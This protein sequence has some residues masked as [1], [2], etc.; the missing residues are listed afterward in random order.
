MST[1]Q[2]ISPDL[3]RRAGSTGDP[4]TRLPAEPEHPVFVLIAD[5]T[6]V[7]P[8]CLAGG[9]LLWRRAALG[10]MAGAGLLLFY[11]MLLI[12]LLPVLV[13][14]AF[15]DGSPVD[16]AG[17]VLMLGCGLICL[18]LFARFVRGAMLEET[19]TISSV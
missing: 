4:A 9:Y 15:Y 6:T 5:F 12:G 19:K 18:T 8:A 16:V 13:F 14:P 17:I 10:Y 7:I 2:T 3:A 1:T 11:S